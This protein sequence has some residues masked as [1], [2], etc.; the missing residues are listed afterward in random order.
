MKTVT[1]MLIDK[2][3]NTVVFDINNLQFK[4]LGIDLTK[5]KHFTSKRELNKEVTRFIES[6]NDE[7]RN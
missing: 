1:L 3:M 2:D 4:S 5:A 6:M 7:K